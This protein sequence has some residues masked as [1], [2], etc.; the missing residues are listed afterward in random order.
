MEDLPKLKAVR[1]MEY[2]DDSYPKIF[3]LEAQDTLL[4]RPRVVPVL[5]KEV[6]GGITYGAEIVSSPPSNLLRRYLILGFERFT[7]PMEQLKRTKEIVKHFE[8]ED[9]YTRM[10][11]VEDQTLEMFNHA[12]K[13]LERLWVSQSPGANDMGNLSAAA[14]LARELI[15]SKRVLFPEG[16]E[17]QKLLM[18]IPAMDPDLS[19]LQYPAEASALYLISAFFYWPISEPEST[20]QKKPWSLWDKLDIPPQ[21][22]LDRS[23]EK[24]WAWYEN[25]TR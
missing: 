24:K 5:P 16:C 1:R 23:L 13:P 14:N 21:V 3:N 6:L 20:V 25:R 8:V 11:I 12:L 4:Y 9:V 22:Q 18:D 15:R 10:T 7:D 19:D 2:P 17:L